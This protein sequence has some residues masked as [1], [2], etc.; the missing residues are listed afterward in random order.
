MGD[1][2]G[3]DLA[4]TVHGRAELFELSD[5]DQGDLR[6]AMLA[7]YRP[8]QGEAF[9]TWLDQEDPMGGRIVADKMFTFSLEG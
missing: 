8:I 6:R 2:P 7:Y 5:P 9:E 1:L 3:D 4:V